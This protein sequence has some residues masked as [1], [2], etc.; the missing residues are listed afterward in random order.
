MSRTKFECQGMRL[1]E[2]HDMF[3][4]VLDTCKSTEEIVP[5]GNHP[6]LI[7]T[8][9]NEKKYYLFHAIEQAELSRQNKDK[10]AKVLNLV[11]DAYQM[12]LESAVN[13][14]WKKQTVEQ[15]LARIE[16][17]THRPQIEQRTK[18]WYEHASQVL[19]ASEL[20][21]LFG[22]DR[23]LWLLLESKAFP[24]E[25][26]T[27]SYQHAIPTEKMNPF[28]WGI[29]FEPVVKMILEHQ[30]KIKIADLGRLFHPT[31]S[32]LAASPDGLIVKSQKES[33]LGRLVEIKC[34]YTRPI[35]GEIPFGYWVQMQSQMEVADID[36]CEY[37]EVQIQSTRP[38]KAE[39]TETQEKDT[40]SIQGSIWGFIYL[41]K[42]DEDYKYEYCPIACVA[43]LKV[44]E[45]ITDE[46][47]ELVE[48]IPWSLV[49]YHRKV[50][51]RDRTWFQATQAW[52][53]AFWADVERVKKGEEPLFIKKVEG[54]A[55]KCLIVDD[56]EAPA[57]QEA[58]AMVS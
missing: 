53:N 56:A 3:V 35:G 4:P 31:D 21:R 40:G 46:G 25:T 19:T 36:E 29:R 26:T 23:D 34:P 52:R 22:S 37:I 28:A 7:N 20:S 54:R 30:D 6:S 55:K 44:G 13:P 32:K 48:V 8:W 11:T 57:S 24:A 49:K 41:W 45:T 33:R 17:L 18:E 9:Y 51:S 58:Q 43:T 1:N 2:Y 14:E 27:G 10:A 38:T 12:F 42:K 5:V 16:H 39:Q 15:K 50:V 47:W